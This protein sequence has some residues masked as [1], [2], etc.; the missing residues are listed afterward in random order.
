MAKFSS[1]FSSSSGNSTYLSCSSGSL[2][3]DA[4]VSFR[5]ISAALRGLGTEPDEIEAVLL[6]HEH[7]D[8]IRGLRAF[9]KNTGAAVYATASVLEYLTAHDHVPP[10]ARLFP[11]DG[12]P[13]A[14]AGME[15]RAFRTPHDSLGSVGYRFHTPD[16]HQIA[17][18]T[19]IGRVTEEVRRGIEGCELVMIESNYDEAML[20]NGPYPYY[21]K[22]RIRSGDGHLSNPDCAEEVARLAQC[23][24]ARFVLAHL[25]RENNR[26]EI[27]GGQIEQRLT[28][29]GLRPGIDYELTVSG[30]EGIGR[31]IRI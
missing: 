27:A 15:V 11:V 8:H 7:I 14:V 29:L 13:F 5:K 2:L 28:S 4:G 25:S 19:D 10:Q 1:L 20:R 18:A 31:L 6:T 17:V 26:P 16:D 3:V 12:R 24:S 23:G 22:A 30:P 21:L 9:V